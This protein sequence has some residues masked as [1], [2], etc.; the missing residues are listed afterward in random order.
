MTPLLEFTL[1]IRGAEELAGDYL[2][3]AELF[4]DDRTNPQDAQEIS[5]QIVIPEEQV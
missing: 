4:Y 5:F 2:V 1:H 3:R